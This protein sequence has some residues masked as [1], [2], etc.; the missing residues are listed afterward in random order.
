[1][2]QQQISLDRATVAKLRLDAGKGDQIFFDADL[3]GFGYRLRNDGGRLRRTWIVQYRVKGRTRRLKI[4]DGAKL[5]ADQARQ[6]ARKALAA[7]TLGQ[8]PQADKESE[9]LNGSRTLRSIA[10][11]YLAMKDLEVQR[12]QYRGSS[13]RVTKLYLTGKYFAPLHAT[14]LTDITVADVAGRLN[15]INRDS[16]TVTAGRARSALSSV[17]AWAMRQGYMG[18]KRRWFCALQVQLVA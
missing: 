4:G 5:N 7:I 13:Y 3:R 2:A 16:G 11:E 9:R 17:F 8:D 10:T 1:M 6:A 18:P 12:G 14:P 15:S